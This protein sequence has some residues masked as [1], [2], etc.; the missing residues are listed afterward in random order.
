ME[1]NIFL[2]YSLA[3]VL[4]VLCILIFS[5]TFNKRDR[6]GI[7]LIS[8]FGIYIGFGGI[9]WSISFLFR[10]QESSQV[11]G[12]MSAWLL[13]EVGALQLSQVMKKFKKVE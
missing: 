3:L 11:L 5:L 1:N 12:L 8:I 2:S 10:D 4:I 13:L 9:I 6:L 7:I